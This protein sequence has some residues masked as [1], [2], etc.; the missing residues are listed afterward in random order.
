MSP[1]IEPQPKNLEEYPLENRMN[2]FRDLVTDIDIP[3]SWPEII[4]ISQR[5]NIDDSGVIT[6][7][8]EE[9]SRRRQPNPVDPNNRD[10]DLFIDMYQPKK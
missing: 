1:E 2:L 8:I 5:Y 6:M 9:T 7:L 10:M 3:L 4:Q